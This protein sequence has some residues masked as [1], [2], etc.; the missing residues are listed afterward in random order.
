MWRE[1]EAA[2][3]AAETGS[4]QTL[5]LQGEP[6]LYFPLVC[7]LWVGRMSEVFTCKRT[8]HDAGGRAA[9]VRRKTNVKAMHAKQVKKHLPFVSMETVSTLRPRLR[10]ELGQAV[11]YQQSEI[12]SRRLRLLQMIHCLTHQ[13]QQPF[14]KPSEEPGS[15]AACERHNVHLR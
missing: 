7:S 5:S 8:C 2:A 10:A 11:P 12:G 1:E 4:V 9:D 14:T 15:T 3:A 13:Q 6:A